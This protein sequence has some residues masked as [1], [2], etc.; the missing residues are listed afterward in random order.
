M[1]QSHH[2][3]AHCEVSPEWRALME[4]SDNR[5]DE[6]PGEV[7]SLAEA[8]PSAADQVLLPRYISRHADGLYVSLQAFDSAS[9]F[10]SFLDRIFG[11]GMRF[12]N[13]DYAN[14]NNLLYY[15]GTPEVGKLTRDL[16]AAGKSSTL[17]LAFD[18]VPFAPQRQKYYQNVKLIEG[19]NAAQYRFEPILAEPAPDT[20]AAPEEI[21]AEEVKLDVDEFIAAMWCK[22]VRFGIDI[23]LIKEA[24]DRNTSEIAVVARMEAATEGKNA[25]VAEL[26]DTLHRSNVPKMLPDGRVDLHQFENRFPQM[27]INTKLIKKVPRIAGKSGWTLTGKEIAPNL[28]QDFDIATLSGPGTRV[29]RSNT[30]EFIVA[31]IAGFL[32]IDPATRLFSISDKIVNREGVSQRTTGNLV[33][34]AEEY[35]EHGIVEEHA[36]VEANHMTF[37]TD[38]FGDLVSRGGKVLL[39]ANLTAGSIK[40]PD[41]LITVHGKASRSS[42]EA[43][44]GT[45]ILKYAESCRIIGAKVSVETAVHCD[46]LAQEVTVDSAEGCTLAG[47]KIQVNTATD[48]HDIETTIAIMVPDMSTLKQQLEELRRQQAECEAIIS[49]KRAERDALSDQQEI[50]TYQLLNAKLRAHE[51]N[52]THEQDANWQKLLVRVAPI[53]KRIRSYND[54][55]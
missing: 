3:M 24:F 19:G 30:G 17:H 5:K 13:L 6:E 51:L 4:T 29:E 43:L 15:W 33:L 53:L 27:E 23:A 26:I 50:K 2:E 40:N 45:I 55:L 41:G 48:R 1:L 39:K 42:I 47:Q 34:N 16:E 14:L 8:M 11:A 36:Q 54:D 44:G 12:V 10:A 31:D 35:E 52:M 28:P 46:I 38:V 21:A 9:H 37:M 22:D 7:N 20:S 32:Q 49:G 18:I 25:T